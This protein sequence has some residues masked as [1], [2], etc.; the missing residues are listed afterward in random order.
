MQILFKSTPGDKILAIKN[1]QSYIQATKRNTTI[2]H[3][4]NN[5]ASTKV[6]LNQGRI[7][8]S[9]NTGQSLAKPAHIFGKKILPKFSKPNESFRFLNYTIIIIGDYISLT[10]DATLFFL[11]VIV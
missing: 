9:K 2:Y 8:V 11:P 7:S 1:K 4:V 3:W 5:I 10:F 6:T